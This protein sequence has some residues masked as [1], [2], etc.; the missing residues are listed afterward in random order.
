MTP[1]T[2]KNVSY[3]IGPDGNPLTTMDLPPADTRRWVARRKAEVVVAVRGGLISL[4]D[5]CDRY[6]LTVEEFL[7]WER[8]IKKFGLPGLRATR[9]QEYKHLDNQ[10]LSA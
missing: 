10:R 5:A 7:S 1:E 4:E 3:V 6:A 8:A 2:Q 9:F